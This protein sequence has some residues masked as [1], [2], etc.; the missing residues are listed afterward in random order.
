MGVPAATGV[1]PIVKYPH[2]EPRPV[3][4]GRFVTLCFLYTGLALLAQAVV[5]SPIDLS[6]G[7]LFQLGVAFVMLATGALRL[8]HPEEE[9]DNPADW[10]LFAYSMAA[11][12]L[13]L[14]GALLVQVLAG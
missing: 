9:R 3:N 14:T 5:L 11:L 13:A 12:A 6:V 7:G 2:R 10:G 8:W 1:T 4:P